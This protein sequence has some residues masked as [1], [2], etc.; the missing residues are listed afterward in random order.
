MSNH[1]A[2][3]DVPPAALAVASIPVVIS[4]DRWWITLSTHTAGEGM[5]YSAYTLRLRLDA[6]SALATRRGVSSRGL[7][8]VT[9]PTHGAQEATG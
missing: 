4:R 8:C 3:L 6:N 2:Q 7:L 1:S 9:V 5:H